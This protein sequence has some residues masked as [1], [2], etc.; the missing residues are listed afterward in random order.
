V[1]A[2]VPILPEKFAPFQTVLRRLL[3]K[4]PGD[5]YTSAE[6]ALNAIFAVKV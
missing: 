2:A 6:A 5:R 3:A 4:E 1:N